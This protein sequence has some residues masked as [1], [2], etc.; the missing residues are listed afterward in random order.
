[1]LNLVQFLSQP[2][3]CVANLRKF[4]VISYISAKKLKNFF[5]NC[6]R[7]VLGQVAGGFWLAKKMTHSIERAIFC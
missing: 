4:L 2:R 3:I 1:M 7:F 6:A 5:F